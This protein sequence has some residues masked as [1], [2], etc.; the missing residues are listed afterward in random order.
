MIISVICDQNLSAEVNDL[1][2]REENRFL[3]KVAG[4]RSS[5]VRTAIYW[6]GTVAV[7]GLSLLLTGVGP[8]FVGPPLTHSHSSSVALTFTTSASCV[9]GDDGSL[10]SGL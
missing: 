9:V 4:V 1:L 5:S 3:R 10:G 8:E 6:S 2:D 7:D